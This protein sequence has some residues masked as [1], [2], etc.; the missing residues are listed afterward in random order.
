MRLHVL[1]RTPCGPFTPDPDSTVARSRCYRCWFR[2]DRA[3]TR[4]VRGYILNGRHFT[5]T[6]QS[7]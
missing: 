3:K 1:E 7:P 4:L 6:E 2:S 5:L